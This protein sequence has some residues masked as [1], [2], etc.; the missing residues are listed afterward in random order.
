MSHREH[1][2]CWITIAA[3]TRDE[4]YDI[5]KVSIGHHN[6]AIHHHV[7]KEAAVVIATATASTLDQPA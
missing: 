3:V 2:Y 6:T 7:M 1:A 5:G 4:Q